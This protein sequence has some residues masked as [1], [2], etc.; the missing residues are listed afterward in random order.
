MGGGRGRRWKMR[1]RGEVERDEGGME[2]G[3]KGEDRVA[4]EG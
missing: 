4:R 1:G 3:K 2:Q